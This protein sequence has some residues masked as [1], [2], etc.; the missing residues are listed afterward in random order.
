[1]SGGMMSGDTQ[2]MMANCQK[3]MR[4]HNMSGASGNAPSSGSSSGMPMSGDMEKMMDDCHKM[5]NSPR[6]GA[7][8]VPPDKEH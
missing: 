5:M 1:M 4:D 2:Q 7:S 6:G 3:M 8:S